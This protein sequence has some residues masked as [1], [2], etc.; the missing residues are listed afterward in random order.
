MQTKEGERE[1][2][3]REGRRK[4]KNERGGEGLSLSMKCEGKRGEGGDR[5]GKKEGLERKGSFE[6]WR[7]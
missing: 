3:G 1:G 4:A 2:L 7:E 6:N 5:E